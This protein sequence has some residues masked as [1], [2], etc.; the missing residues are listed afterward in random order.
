MAADLPFRGRP[1]CPHVRRRPRGDPPGATATPPRRPQQCSPTPLNR[2]ICTGSPPHAI[3]PMTPP[4]VSWRRSA[5]GTR[6]TFVTT[7]T[8]EARNATAF[9]SP[10]STPDQLTPTVQRRC[11]ASA[12][13]DSTS[14]PKSLGISDGDPRPWN[15]RQL[16][17]PVFPSPRSAAPAS[18]CSC[19]R[20]D[21][22]AA[23]LPEHHPA[24][25]HCRRTGLS[26]A[27]AQRPVD[28]ALRERANR[29][30]D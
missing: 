17:L 25:P 20:S 26:V 5:R 9:C 16:K 19:P 18:C 3:R 12:S 13:P 8:S 10:P 14:Y 27:L 23:H 4:A 2:Q 22:L 1:G 7:C 24:Y 29:D 15:R 6:A 28:V 11:P 30:T 21:P